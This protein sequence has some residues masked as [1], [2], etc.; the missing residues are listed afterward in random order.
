M[1]MPMRAIPR[2]P[3]HTHMTYSRAT[4]T[5][6]CHGWD[7]EG[8]PHTT[9]DAPPEWTRLAIIEENAETVRTQGDLL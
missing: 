9:D 1:T 3:R 2:C 8:C 4:A 5:W 7:G 6:V